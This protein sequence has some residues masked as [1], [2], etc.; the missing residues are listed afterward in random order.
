[1]IVTTKLNHCQPAN[2]QTNN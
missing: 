1:M 2:Y